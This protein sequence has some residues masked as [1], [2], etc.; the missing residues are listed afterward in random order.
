MDRADL[1]EQLEKAA[2]A[3]S[4][5]EA[6]IEHQRPL[7]ARLDKAAE[8]TSEARALLDTLVKRHSLAFAIRQYPPRT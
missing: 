7:I 4:D 1:T 8:D 2:A 6:L 5:G 3:V